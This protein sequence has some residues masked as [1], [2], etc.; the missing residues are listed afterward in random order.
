M[1]EASITKSI[2]LTIPLTPRHDQLFFD[3]FVTAIEGGMT[4][5]WARIDKYRWSV[6]QDGETEDLLGFHAVLQDVE[7]QDQPIFEVNRAIILTGLQRLAFGEVPRMEH[8]GG[9]ALGALLRPEHAD[10]D[11]VDADIVV[12]AGLFG[13]VVY[14]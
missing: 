5:G 7:D 3:L 8:F 4:T 14:G 12:Q 11:A 10:F 1:S 2:T 6:G 13:E 9:K